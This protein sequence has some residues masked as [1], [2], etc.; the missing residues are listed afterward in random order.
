MRSWC[1]LQVVAV[2]INYATDFARTI[3]CTREFGSEIMGTV[4]IE[5]SYDQKYLINFVVT[6]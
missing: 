2:Q 6:A 1:T 4:T 3:K 5:T